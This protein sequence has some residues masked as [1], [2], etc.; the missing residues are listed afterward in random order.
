MLC[1]NPEGYSGGGEAQEGGDI[2]ILTAHARFC[3]A[4][5]NRTL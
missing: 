5:T 4:K 3:T 1:D 2:C